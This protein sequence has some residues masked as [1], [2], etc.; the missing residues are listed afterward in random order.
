MRI[1]FI[2]LMILLIV[3]VVAVAVANQEMVT[4][5][6]L[7]GQVELSVFSVM[8]GS[9][10]AGIL[11]MVCFYIYRS[12]HNYFKSGSDRALKKELQQKIKYLESENK[13]LEEEVA[14]L[15]KE[16]ENAEE[17]ARKELET[18]K[19]RLE[20]ELESQKK[21]REEAAASEQAELEA[22]KEKLKEELKKQQKDQGRSEEQVDIGFPPKKG[23]WDFLKRK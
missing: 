7:F 23:F 12:I 21:E 22:E 2:V 16:R 15:Q 1:F 6:Y 14:R 19:N 8:L 3:A 5:D 11:I 13:K 18:E 9:A 17:R 4:I 20:A 10:S